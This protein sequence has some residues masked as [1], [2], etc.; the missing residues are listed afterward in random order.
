MNNSKRNVHNSGP[1]GMLVKSGQVKQI[2]TDADGQKKAAEVEQAR[3]TGFYFRT[4][5]GID[6]TENELLEVDPAE[7]E[8]WEYANRL[9]DEM[10]DINELVES[11]R[12]SK[13]LQPALIRLHPNPHNGIK[14][15]IIFGRRRHAAC[16]QLGIP[17][18]AIKKDINDIQD[19]IAT[20]DAEN[21]FRKDV[22][23]YSNALL[24]KRLLEDGV[25]K[26]GKELAEKLGMSA[27]SLNEL[28]AYTKIPH[29]I[30]KA[31]P[32]I[33]MLSNSMALKIAALVNLSPKHHKYILSI[34]EEIGKTITSP[35]RLEKVV[36]KHFLNKKVETLEK[37]KIIK[38]SNGQKLFTFKMGHKG[39]PC[40][41]IHKE[42]SNNIDHNDLCK[43]LKAYLEKAKTNIL[44]LQEA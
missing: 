16:L 30:V 44:D 28:M 34:A 42:L 8:P 18:L 12:Q 40:I 22:S 10:S 27:S 11:I 43:Y 7:C 20:Q 23:N 26:T 6:F 3:S 41:V 1:L 24:Y 5:S 17:L 39:S 15:E 9:D 33:H 37:A 29:D 2:E 25:F 13:Q 36:E 21:K 19:A 38:A 4:Q 32:D 14:Y 31:I 35:A